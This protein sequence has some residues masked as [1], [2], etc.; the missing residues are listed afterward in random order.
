VNRGQ[1]LL[2]DTNVISELVR[3]NPDPG[4]ARWL[5]RQDPLL[6]HLS[7][8]S[9]GELAYGIARLPAGGRRSRLESW[10]DVDIR[11]QFA[12]RVLDFGERQALA[13]GGL[14]ARCERQGSPRPAIELQIAATAA[15]ADLALCT[16]N[17]QYFQDL[18]IDLV[19]PWHAR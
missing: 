13:W 6:A 12:G 5:T 8:I 11:Q 2:L 1:G 3:E 19:D 16:R 15:T 9:L 10:L 17:T 14:R 7:T 18:G 4:V